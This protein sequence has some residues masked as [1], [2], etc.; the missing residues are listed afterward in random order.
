MTDMISIDELLAE[1]KAFL[2]AT[3]PVRNVDD[4]EFVWGQ[5]SD[6]LNVLEE[7]DR[8]HLDEVVAAAK[9]YAAARDDAGFGWIDGPVEY[10]GRGLSTDHAIAFAELEGQYELPN[11]SILVIAL[12]FV[13]PALRSVASPEICTELLPKLYRG[14]LIMCQLFSEPDAGSDL[15]SATTRAVRDGDEWLVTGQKVWTSSAHAADLGICVCRT[16]PDAPKHRGL[17]TFLV[18]MH[19]E[20]V[21]IRP[22]VQMTGEANFNEVFL[23]EVRVPDSMRVGDVNSGFGVILTVL[24]NERSIATRAPKRGGGVG[25]FERI[26]GVVHEYGDPTDPVTRQRLATVYSSMRIREMMNARWRASLKPDETPGPEMMLQKIGNAAFNRELVH[27]LGEVLGPHLIADAGEWGSYA[28]ANY[29]LSTPGMRI[30]GGTEEI[31]RNTIG[32]RV[33]GLPREPKA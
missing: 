8:E 9:G 15:A 25:P 27:L 19:A 18:D 14:D 1:G 7:V 28:W 22:L 23:S 6:E 20:G 33:L 3:V 16:D 11:L 5:G 12:G 17:T 24:G 31:V 4:E 10:G 2:D 30:G 26:L 21:E 29:V 13:G 32:E